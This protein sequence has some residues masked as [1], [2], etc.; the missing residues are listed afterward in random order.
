MLA[1]ALGD[2]KH[3]R[4]C[5]F[6]SCGFDETICGGECYSCTL[7]MAYDP[8]QGDKDT[9]YYCDRR[10]AMCGSPRAAG[11]TPIAC[12]HHLHSFPS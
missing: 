2:C 8:A 10:W 4:D 7:Q 12:T 6:V 1:Q 9:H 3:M 11:P 5:A